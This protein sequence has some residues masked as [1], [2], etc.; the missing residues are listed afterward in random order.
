VIGLLGATG[1]T[2]R[3][4]AAELAR[5]QLPHRLGARDPKRLATLPSSPEGEHFVVDVTQR[6]RLDAFFDHLDVLITTVGPFAHLGWTV[7]EA[8]VAHDVPYVDSTGEP[9]FIAAIYDRYADAA[10][11]VVPG[12][13]FEFLPGDLAAAVAAA[14]LAGSGPATPEGPN[15]A[16][17]AVGVHYRLDH[18]LPS[19]GTAQT[20][21]DIAASTAIN[22]KR[23]RVAFPKG[24]HEAVELP[25]GEQL[26]VPRHVPGAKVSCTFAVPSWLSPVSIPGVRLLG[27]LAPRLEGVAKRLPEG[28]SEERRRRARFTIVA[29]ALGPAGRRAVCCTGA[30]VYGLTARFLVEAAVRLQGKERKREGQ[31]GLRRGA[32]APA[33]ALAPVSTLDAISGSHPPGEF[34]WRRL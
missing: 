28:P 9:N 22:P 5:R 13:G 10:S 15:G 11:P 8:A 30:D 19:R 27:R 1:Y 3:L 17:T 16:V 31:E 21:I 24:V 12:C 29:E 7:A 18:W 23:R 2:G 33:E 34:S 14:D 32:L 25:W 26:M 4:V 6:S 20:A